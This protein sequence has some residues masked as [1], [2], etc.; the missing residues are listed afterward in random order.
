MRAASVFILAF[1]SISTAYARAEVSL[2]NGNFFVSLRDFSYP[3]GIEPKIERVYNSKSDF[4]G[5]FGYSWGTAYEVH[6]EQDPDGSLVLTEY[7][8]GASIR[9]TPKNASAK[10]TEDAVTMILD[11][12]KKSGAIS[13]G[14]A[15]E[16]YRNKLLSDFSFRSKQYAGMIAKGFLPRKPVVEGSQFTTTQY[17]YQYI[18]KVKGGYIRTM[19]DGG[20]QKFNEAGK[21]VQIADSRKNYVNFS[22]DKNN[23]L[24]Q[25]VDNQNRKINLAYNNDGLVEKITGES[26]K[27]ASFRYEKN[28]TL[29]YSKDDSGVE[30]SFKYTRDEYLNLTE[31]G[32][33]NEKN[34]KGQQKRMA[35]QYYG[36]DKKNSVKSV[37]NPDGSV[38]EYDYVLSAP[39][40]YSVKVLTKDSNGAKI[41][42]A[43][44]EYFF[45]PRKDGE[46]FTWKMITNMDGD[47]TET[48]YD[49][50][51]GFPAKVTRNGRVTTMEYDLKGRMVKKTT[52]Y[53]ST[54]LT[55]D[56][57]AG[58]VSKV[59]KKLK[60]GTVRWSEFQ[61]DPSN[62]NLV[63][64]RNSEKKSVKLVYDS[65]NLIH[66]L[67]DDQNHTLTFKYNELSRPIEIQDSKKGS[68]KFTY[69]NSGEVDKIDSNGGSS[70]AAEIMRALQNL[71]DITAPAGVT[72]SI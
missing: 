7:G 15:L 41:T 68:V 67:V 18:T 38:I 6:I 14:K 65:K 54:E 47:V 55:Y 56:Q 53:E 63:F 30:N 39:D 36:P 34:D 52:P 72:M 17:Q 16:D 26:G 62:S 33:L 32:Y 58:K 25:M 40:H 19:G 21:L 9:F 27:N 64:A 22:Y 46:E 66:A 45:K 50:R 69:K 24:V 70:V 51:L 44:Y 59:V 20:S 61:Y 8:G 35:I 12:A 42:D 1:L 13:S 11:A 29:V 4:Y 23:R 28:K 48:V 60:S 31:I 43:K 2:R 3:G 37:A 57:K 5:M 71:I 10:G 49:D